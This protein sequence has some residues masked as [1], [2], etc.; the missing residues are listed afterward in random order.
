MSLLRRVLAGASVTAA[1]AAAVLVGGATPA[2]AEYSGTCIREQ[3]TR[4]L[5]AN[6]GDIKLW[7]Q[8]VTDQYGNQST[9]ICWKSSSVS[10]GDIVY[11]SPFR[12]SPIPTVEYVVNDSTCRNYFTIEDPVQLV[13]ELEAYL[14]SNPAGFCLGIGENRA[15]RVELGTPSIGFPGVE[16]WLDKGTELTNAYCDALDLAGIYEFQCWYSYYNSVRVV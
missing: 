6:G 2:A 14:L 4:L 13:T 7:V 9:H 8:N 3:S 5:T 12:G 11:R 15:V 16:V 1:V 10:G